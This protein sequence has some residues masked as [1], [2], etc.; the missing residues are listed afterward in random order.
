LIKVRASSILCYWA[1]D[2]LR[3]GQ[4]GVEETIKTDTTGCK[5]GSPKG[6]RS[7]KVEIIFIASVFIL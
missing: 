1:T 3:I 5:P 7:D 4:G 6:E 2:I